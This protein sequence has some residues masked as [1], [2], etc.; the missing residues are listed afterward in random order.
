M[1]AIEGPYR[2][3]RLRWW[4]RVARWFAYVVGGE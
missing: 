3:E 2:A 4:H 1:M